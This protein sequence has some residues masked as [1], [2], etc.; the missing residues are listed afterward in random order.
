MHVDGQDCP[1]LPRTG[2]ALKGHSQVWWDVSCF[3]EDVSP[4]QV[5]PLGVAGRGAGLEGNPLK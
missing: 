4:D 3:G 2:V 1:H 5:S